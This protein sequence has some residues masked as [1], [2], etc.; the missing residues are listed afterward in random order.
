MIALD[1]VIV[2]EC[3]TVAALFAPVALPGSD[4]FAAMTVAVLLPTEPVIVS[5]R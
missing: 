3:R 1:T 2:V 5:P 4:W